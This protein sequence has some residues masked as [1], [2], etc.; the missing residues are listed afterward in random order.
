MPKAKKLIVDGQIFQ[1]DAKDRGMGRYSVAL[2]QSLLKFTEE[3]QS[4]EILLSNNLPTTD[5]EKDELQNMFDGA[6]L[7]YIDLHITLNNKIEHAIFH[8]EALLN[9]YV[10]DSGGEVDFLIASLFQ[11]PMVSVFPKNVKKLLIFYD[12]IPYL[13]HKRYE[14]LMPFD[15]YLNLFL[16]PTKYSRF[17]KQFPTICTHF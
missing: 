11:E 3:Y 15:N 14:S 7:K 1:T 16:M 5:K 8:N 12:L 6:T 4:V 2:I 10:A 13:Y 9:N 17:P